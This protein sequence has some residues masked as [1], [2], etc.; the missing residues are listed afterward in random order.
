MNARVRAMAH[1]LMRLVTRRCAL[2][3][4]QPER[5]GHGPA[6]HQRRGFGAV[7]VRTP[8]RDGQPPVA[9]EVTEVRD[10]KP[11]TTLRATVTRDDGVVALEGTA[12]CYTMPM[13]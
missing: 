13:S 8:L 2:A 6:G 5:V 10:D 9:D 4:A 12:V 7:P 11:I 1:H 3:A